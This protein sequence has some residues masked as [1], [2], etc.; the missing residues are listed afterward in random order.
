[1]LVLLELS[2][3]SQSAFVPDHL[4]YQSLTLFPS[5]LGLARLSV[6]LVHLG[7]NGL[8]VRTRLERLQ[9]QPDL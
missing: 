8:D 7:R 5:I 4:R 3:G 2:R 1:M 9:V 6:V